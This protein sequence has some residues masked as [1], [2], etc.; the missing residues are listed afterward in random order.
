MNWANYTLIIMEF[1]TLGI[2]MGRHG[3]PKNENYNFWITLIS[4]IITFILL[5]FGGWFK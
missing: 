2:A 4:V 1:I 5:Y 3:T